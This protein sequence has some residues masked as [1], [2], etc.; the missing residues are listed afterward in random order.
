MKFFFQ[1]FGM[2]L[3]QLDLDAINKRLQA[4]GDS[5]DSD[6]ESDNDSDDKTDDV[7]VDS[8]DDITTLASKK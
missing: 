5:D 6:D 2:C 7:V 8:D 1:A 4:I 3:P